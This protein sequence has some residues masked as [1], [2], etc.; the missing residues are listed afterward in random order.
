[1]IN[2][3]EIKQSMNRYLDIS[4]ALCD[5]M[6]TTDDGDKKTDELL[7]YAIWIDNISHNY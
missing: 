5:V 4:N 2:I 3:S 1:M 6:K 7:P